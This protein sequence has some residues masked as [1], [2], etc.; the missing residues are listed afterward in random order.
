MVHPYT[1]VVKHA[2]APSTAAAVAVVRTVPEVVPTPV[3]IPGH[4]HVVVVVVTV[5]GKVVLLAS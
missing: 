2:T 5:V 1:A 4:M 3:L